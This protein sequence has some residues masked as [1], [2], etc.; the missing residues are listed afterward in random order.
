MLIDDDYPAVVFGSVFIA[1]GDVIG[2]EPF[3]QVFD[4]RKYGIIRGEF[5]EVIGGLEFKHSWSPPWENP[6]GWRAGLM[7]KGWLG[8]AGEMG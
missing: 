7:E 3:D 8:D 6:P 5:G 2:D 1:F 4:D